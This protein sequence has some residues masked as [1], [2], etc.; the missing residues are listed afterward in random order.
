M[1]LVHRLEVAG[2]VAPDHHMQHHQHHQQQWQQRRQAR[3]ARAAQVQ[4]ET[5]RT[6]ERWRSFALGDLL[7]G[8][9]GQQQQA[10]QRLIEAVRLHPQGACVAKL[11]L[12][13][14]VKEDM[15][16]PV[17][18]RLLFQHRGVIAPLDGVS[19]EAAVH[20]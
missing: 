4:V 10:V 13:A 14:A 8:G 17:C 19:D 16:V 12:F 11:H 18:K 6:E 15:Y 2:A 20:R 5:G 9:T 7:S 3:S 1:H